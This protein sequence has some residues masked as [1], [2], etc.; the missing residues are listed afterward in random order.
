MPNMNWR[1]RLSWCAAALVL[2]AA[3]GSCSRLFA[4]RI[5]EIKAHPDGYNGR[6]VTIVGTVTRS[7]N[8]LF[9]KYFTVKDGSG[10]IA[11]VTDRPLP[12]E[13]KRI[14]VK[15]RVNRAFAIGSKVV[16]VIV[17]DPDSR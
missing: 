4:T 2:L 17:E 8:L 7:V 14:T 12:G 5:G 3:V 13:G 11:V 6:H 10:E 15:G 1:V 9:V 16:E